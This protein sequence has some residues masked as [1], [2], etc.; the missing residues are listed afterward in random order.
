MGG[1]TSCPVHGLA[2][3]RHRRPHMGLLDRLDRIHVRQ[4]FHGRK[5][6]SIPGS[7]ILYPSASSLVMH[8]INNSHVVGSMAPTSGGQYHWVSEFAPRRH[9]KQISYVMGWLCVLG[10][11]GGCAS[12][13]FMGG[14]TIQGIIVLNNPDYVYENWHGTLLTIAISAFG[15]FFNTFLARRLALVEGVILV[16]HV[17]A[18]FG[19]LVTLW[20]LSPIGDAGTVFTQFNDGGDWGSLGGSALVGITAAVSC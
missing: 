7:A 2:Q 5:C 10:W 11:Q 12:T 9:Q 3:W 17:S 16:F 18:F 1:C 4:H 14:T 8:R 15:V 20:V 13:A 19:I 6:V